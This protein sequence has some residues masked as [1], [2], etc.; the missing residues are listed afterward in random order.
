MTDYGW[1]FHQLIVGMGHAER[2]LSATRYLLLTCLMRLT[3]EEVKSVERPLN[4]LDN[5]QFGFV[6][7]YKFIEL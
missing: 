4:H 2:R 6:A 3:N 1:G 5:D 7:I